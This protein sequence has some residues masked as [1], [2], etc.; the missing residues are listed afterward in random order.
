[1]DDSDLQIA[2]QEIQ[3]DLARLALEELEG[4]SDADLE[5]NIT[6]SEIQIEG[7]K[8]KIE[9]RV[10]RAPFDGQVVA[11]GKGVQDIASLSK[12][13]PIKASDSIRAFEP[14]AV[15]AKVDRLEM[16]VSSLRERA[17]EISVG[18]VV[19][20]TSPLARDQPF[21]TEVIAI[22]LERLGDG[23]EPQKPQVVRF[24]LPSDAP[25][26]IEVQDYVE[27]TVLS[28]IHADT[29]FLPPAAIR[30]FAG[31]T[32][33]MLQEGETRRN[34][35]ILTGLRNDTQVEILSGLTEG[36]VVVGQ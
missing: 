13:Q 6:K 32:F 23:A 14:I 7:L 10:L 16:V 26:A 2:L 3:V 17:Q 35:D 33:A 21:L 28:A 5:R 1:M 19:T 31:R 11:V 12:G 27:I 20:A 29:L 34:V 36:Q 4:G 25:E 9:E 30:E 15:I 8:R 18:Q 22:P 24:S